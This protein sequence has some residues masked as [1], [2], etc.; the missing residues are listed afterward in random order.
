MFKFNREFDEIWKKAE[1][2]NNRLHKSRFLKIFQQNKRFSTVGLY[3]SET[4]KYVIFDSINFAGN[5][6]YEK[7]TMPAEFIEMKRMLSNA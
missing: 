6:R 7:N 5:F 1:E 2:T 3:D 4:K